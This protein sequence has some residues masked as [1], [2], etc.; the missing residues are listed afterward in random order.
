MPVFYCTGDIFLSRA[1]T[2]AHGVNCRGKM[3]RG[4]AVEFKRRFPEMFKEYKRR[5]HK[6]ELKPGG[7][8]LE[9]DITPWVLNLATQDTTR[10]ARLGY[11]KTCFHWVAHN[12]KKL[13]ITSLAIPRI[14]AGLGGLEWE[15][16]SAAIDDILGA[17]SI[18][19]YVYEYYEPGISGEEV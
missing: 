17:L 14:G 13:G 8:Y 11:V 7:A 9:K 19:I 16:V 2:L 3:G 1:Q 5:C 10:G 18:P 15:E 12:Y 4:L 6:K